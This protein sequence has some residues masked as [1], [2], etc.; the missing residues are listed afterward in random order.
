[1]GE[2]KTVHELWALVR[3]AIR[4]AL[5]EIGVDQPVEPIRPPDPAMGHLG[6][7]VFSLARTLRRPPDDIARDVAARLPKGGLFQAVVPFKG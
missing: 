1:V 7:P 4:K 3:T 2:I 6:F 5:E